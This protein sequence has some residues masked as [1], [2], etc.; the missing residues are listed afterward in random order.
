MVLVQ[1]QNVVLE[2]VMQTLA[3]LQVTTATVLTQTL[4]LQRVVAEVP[5]LVELPQLLLYLLV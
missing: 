2:H 1:V 3:Q 4:G 5:V